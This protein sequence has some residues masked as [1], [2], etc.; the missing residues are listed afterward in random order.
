MKQFDIFISYA[1]KDN[2]KA[3]L[4]SSYLTKLGWRVWKDQRL[5]VGNNFNDEIAGVLSNSK[6]IM[7][8]WSVSSVSSAW[9]IK[10][11]N[12]A[13][14]L[15]KYF[16]LRL[17]N[18]IM[19]GD[20]ANY[21]AESLLRWNGDIDEEQFEQI[22]LQVNEK[23]PID[24]PVTN[25]II[26]KARARRDFFF[27]ASGI[28]NSLSEG[29]K[30]RSEVKW[31]FWLVRYI[32]SDS[33]EAFNDLIW[34]VGGSPPYGGVAYDEASAVYEL[35]EDY[36]G[37]GKASE[38]SYAKVEKFII[39]KP[40]EMKA[41]EA[42]RIYDKVVSNSEN[43][44]LKDLRI[45]N[46][47]A[48][49]VVDQPLTAYFNLLKAGVYYREGDPVNAYQFAIKA[50]DPL[51][52][53]QQNDAVYLDRLAAALTNSAVFANLNGDM[54]EA[55]RCAFELKKIGRSQMLMNFQHLLSEGP[56]ISKTAEEIEETAWHLMDNQKNPYKAIEW[57]KE[58]EKKYRIDGNYKELSGLLGDMAVCYRRMGNIQL[59]IKTNRKAIEEAQR[60]GET[61]SIYR[62]CQNLAGI[63][64]RNKDYQAAFPYLR[65]S[66]YAAAKL[67]DPNEI[68][69]SASALFEFKAY[70]LC[71]QE[72]ITEM[73]K[74]ALELLDTKSKSAGIKKSRSILEDFIEGKLHLATYTD[75]T[76][77]QSPGTINPK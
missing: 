3:D 49:D 26:E 56:D 42:F 76:G 21:H 39:N 29:I 44:T 54:A 16:P 75:D 48:V 65:L 52:T 38:G 9:V 7:V 18:V 70:N 41:M 27:N 37:E 43:Y 50:V 19:P 63:L 40:V 15:N 53:F 77:N 45:G 23:I 61:I 67:A 62:W 5:S 64:M 12:L 47:D 28:W 24:N 57:Y 71:T 59:A 66:L 35:L 46:E 22:C 74:T 68:K 11:A 51:L 31:P 32:A 55:R 73:Y 30:E 8:L 25:K 6:L 4:I 69:L 33:K 2:E 34:S 13:L 20:L 58:A 72:E 60:A 36:L 10:E 17:E 1:H 14:S